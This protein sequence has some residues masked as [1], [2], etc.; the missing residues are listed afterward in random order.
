V[1]APTAAGRG[2]VITFHGKSQPST[3]TSDDDEAMDQAAVAAGKLEW[4][5]R[6]K[7]DSLAVGHGDVVGPAHDDAGCKAGVN[8]SRVMT[9]PPAEYVHLVHKLTRLGP[10]PGERARRPRR[11]PDLLRSNRAVA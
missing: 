3:A 4:L 11:V 9:A 10:F 6:A 7:G 1:W 2:A 5:R 8:L